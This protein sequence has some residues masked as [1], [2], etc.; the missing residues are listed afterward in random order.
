MTDSRRRLEV[1]DASRDKKYPASAGPPP[2]QNVF[3][4]IL[5]TLLAAGHVSTAMGRHDCLLTAVLH[6]L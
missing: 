2:A 4:T 1:L 5:K 3:R 6:W